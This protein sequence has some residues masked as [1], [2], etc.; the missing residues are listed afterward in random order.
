VPRAAAYF[1]KDTAKA[2]AEIQIAIHERWAAGFPCRL[3]RSASPQIHRSDPTFQ[4][5]MYL[6]RASSVNA[7]TSDRRLRKLETATGSEDIRHYLHRPLVEWPD[8]ILQL[9]IDM[10]EE[11]LA[12][13]DAGLSDWSG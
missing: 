1:S 6:Y 5:E 11:E 4:P 3:A 7:R 13:L 9:A 12:R 2:A 10:G 8:H